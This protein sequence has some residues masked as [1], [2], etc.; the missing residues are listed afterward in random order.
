M[1]ESCVQFLSTRPSTPKPYR[2][3]RSNTADL[4]ISPLAEKRH[5]PRDET[6]EDTKESHV[7]AKIE[8]SVNGH[9]S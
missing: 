8:E 7:P 9:A 5:G 2:P 1:I 6:P 3:K 4:N